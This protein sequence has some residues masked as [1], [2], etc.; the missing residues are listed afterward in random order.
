MVVIF[1]VEIEGDVVFFFLGLVVLI[2]FIEWVSIVL[3]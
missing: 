1:V 2:C 3:C